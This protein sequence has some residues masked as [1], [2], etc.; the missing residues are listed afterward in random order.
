MQAP[1]FIQ[2]YYQNKIIKNLPLTN[3]PKKEVVNLNEA[4]HIG[5]VYY[6]DD[7][8]TYRL[9]SDFVKNL[10]AKDKSV[11]AIGF[12]KD[13]YLTK[14]YLP[15]LSYDFF[16]EKD[17]NWYGRP[18]GNYVDE[19]VRTDFDILI[20][21]SNGDVFPIRYLLSRARAKTKIGL[22]NEK[23]KEL[24]DLFIKTDNYSDIKLLINQIE[25]YLSIINKK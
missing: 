8:K 4:N 22:F 9:I 1:I 12:V 21:L 19:F 7:D 18:H 10:Q 23:N 13:K 11:K 2:N 6:L 5:I 15:K 20:D 3:M 14:R 24:L 16:Y 25:Y 17:L